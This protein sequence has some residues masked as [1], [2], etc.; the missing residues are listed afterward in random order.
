MTSHLVS[1][2]DI[3]DAPKSHSCPLC[4]EEIIGDREVI[5]LHFARH[6]EEIALGILPQ[7]YESD[8]NSEES[9]DDSMEIL[10]VGALRTE[11][12]DEHS[13]S[14]DNVNPQ[15]KNLSPEPELSNN[16]AFDSDPGTVPAQT[17]DASNTK[18][19]MIKCIC[20]YSEGDGNSVLCEICSKWQ[21]VGCF[22]KSVQDIPEVHLCGDCNPRE[23][24]PKLAMSIHGRIIMHQHRVEERG[25]YPHQLAESNT[26]PGT[27]E[28]KSNAEQKLQEFRTAC[29]ACF[30][31]KLICDMLRPSCSCCCERDVSCNYSA[32][33]SL[34]PSKIPNDIESNIQATTLK[35][36]QDTDSNQKASLEL[37][38]RML[39]NIS[40]DISATALPTGIPEQL[41]KTFVTSSAASQKRAYPCSPCYNADISCDRG[42]PTCSHCIASG[43]QCTPAA[44]LPRSKEAMQPS[45]GMLSANV[46][47][48]SQKRGP[49]R[50]RLNPLAVP[51]HRTDAITDHTYTFDERT[52]LYAAMKDTSASTRSPSS[53]QSREIQSVGGTLSER[54]QVESSTEE[55]R[56]PFHKTINHELLEHG[57]RTTM[58]NN[59]KSQMT[60]DKNV[61]IKL[62]VPFNYRLSLQEYAMLADLKENKKLTWKQIPHFFPSRSV[63]FLMKEYESWMNPNECQD[64]ADAFVSQTRERSY[65]QA[66]QL[67]SIREARFMA[68]LQRNVDLPPINQLIRDSDGTTQAVA[69]QDLEKESAGDPFLRRIM[70]ENLPDLDRKDDPTTPGQLDQMSTSQR[71]SQIQKFSEPTSRRSNVIFTENHNDI[72]PPPPPPGTTT[73]T[74]LTVVTSSNLP[75]GWYQ[76]RKAVNGNDKT[77]YFTTSG[78]TQW[79]RPTESFVPHRTEGPALEQLMKRAKRENTLLPTDLSIDGIGK[80]ERTKVRRK[81]E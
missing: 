36:E 60:N 81:L 28:P 41:I 51:H 35:M 31:A 24:D 23:I 45:P 34:V 76:A 77:Y 18:E 40:R 70:A 13:G 58:P 20:G 43:V 8:T 11:T 50:M 4:L 9:G 49:H 42:Y 57:F 64:L 16:L 15:N 61:R 46:P 65:E 66:D 6:M 55:D 14:S 54:Q 71:S 17:S 53:S 78:H 37:K 19:P 5:S 62:P 74:D 48:D 30:R 69:H 56:S 22:Y 7:S 59:E 38:Q 12:L 80:P 32:P 72:P 39:R 10:S 21:H 25:G 44:T 2:H 27:G 3:P 67:P 26:G 52:G 29:D 68:G 63:S 47:N 79:E 1:H 73:T 33:S 75:Q